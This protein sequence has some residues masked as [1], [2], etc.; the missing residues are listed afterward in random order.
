MR[1]GSACYMLAFI[2]GVT[3][4][5]AQTGGPPGGAPGQTA[6]AKPKAAAPKA[7]TSAAAPA[8]T[9]KLLNKY[10]DWS[11]FEHETQGSKVCFI[12]SRPKD[13]EPKSAN[14]SPVYFYLTT[15][16]KD[17]VR[18]EVSVKIGY[19]FKANSAPAVIVGAEQ[20]ELFP[21]EDKAFMRDPAEERKLLQAMSNGTAMVVKGVSVRGTETT[22]QYSLA[23]F[24][25]AVK[26]IEQACQ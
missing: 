6:P 24:S 10:N 4:A 12:T 25:S 26:D 5:L 18:N 9:A 8:Q 21:R 7:K 13:M 23:G 20:F 22:D 16:Q 17:G 3:H 14:R 11:V 2:F 15:W 1:M 19:T